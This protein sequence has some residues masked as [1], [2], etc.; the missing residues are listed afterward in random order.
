MIKS[1]LEHVS[2]K[3]EDDSFEEG[4]LLPSERNDQ[5]NY[6]NTDSGSKVP[7]KYWKKSEKP[8]YKPDKTASLRAKRVHKGDYNA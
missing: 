3:E 1:F 5:K 4:S 2:S 7:M 8:D 6:R